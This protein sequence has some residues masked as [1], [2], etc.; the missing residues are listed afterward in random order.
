MVIARHFV[1]AMIEQAREQFPNEGCGLL[2][3]ENGKVVKFY[4]IENSDSSP[5]HYKMDPKQQLHAM[6]EI[7]DNDWDL[8]A[9]YHSHTHTRAYPSPE[10]RRLAFYPETLYL[11]LSLADPEQPIMHAYRMDGDDV[12]EES[13]EVV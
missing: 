12:T 6:L 13:I 8:A 4:P 2:A 10:D 1:E 7:E 9:I 11:I 5:V 3:A